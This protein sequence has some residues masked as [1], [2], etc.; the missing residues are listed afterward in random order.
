MTRALISVSD[1]TGIVAFAQ[2]LVEQGVKS[3]QQEEQSMCW[4]KLGSKRFR[5]KK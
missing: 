3:Y 1:K 4:I 5:S 2:G